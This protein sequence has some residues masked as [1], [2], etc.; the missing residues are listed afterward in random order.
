MERGTTV[1]RRRAMRRR[2][3]L[4][5]RIEF[6]R[7]AFDCVIRNLSDTGAK[8]CCDEEIAL[9]DVFRLFIERKGEL[10]DV[11]AVWRARDGIGLE[12]L[13]AE[14]FGNVLVFEPARGGPLPQR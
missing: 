10:R 6:E 5:G 8:I 7:S 14:E 3:L 4:T 9:P 12:F 11:R 13:S 1:E 2:T